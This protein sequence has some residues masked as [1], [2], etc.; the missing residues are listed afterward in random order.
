MLTWHAAKFE[1]AKFAHSKGANSVLQERLST[2]LALVFEE[3]TF[4]YFGQLLQ[5]CMAHAAVRVASAGVTNMQFLASFRF[6]A[7]CILF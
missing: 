5:F 6:L 1:V 4:F 7:C 2:F 3:I